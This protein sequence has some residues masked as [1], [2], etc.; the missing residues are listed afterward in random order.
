MSDWEVYLE[1]ND[2]SSN[3]F[4]RGKADGSEFVVNYGRIGTNGQTKVKDLGSPEKASAELEKVAN[5][6]RKK[7]YDDVEGGG[8][9]A[10]PEPVVDNT[11]KVKNQKA[12]YVVKRAGKTIEV[13][14][15]TDGSTIETE[16]EEKLDSPEAAAAAF[17]SIQETLVAAGYKK[18]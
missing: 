6:K 4:W 3:K 2:G 9:A 14:I 11:P 10:A 8:S 13:E 17:D 15:E 12:K 7:G 5:K 16:I 1:F 18:A